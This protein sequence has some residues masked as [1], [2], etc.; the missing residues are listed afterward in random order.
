[1][2]IQLRRTA[3]P[4]QSYQSREMRGCGSWPH[5]I[6]GG[7]AAAPGEAQELLTDGWIWTPAHSVAAAPHPVL[8]L[9]KKKK[10]IRVCEG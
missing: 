6:L 7:S 10:I 5:V 8:F 2:I 3:F 1:M 4:K 9:G